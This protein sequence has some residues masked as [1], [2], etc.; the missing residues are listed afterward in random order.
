VPHR[1]VLSFE[2]GLK[3]PATARH[4]LAARLPELSDDARRDAMIV[5]SELVTNAVLAGARAL[6][7]VVEND[8]RRLRVEVEED[9][10]S[11]PLSEWHGLHL[12]AA[13]AQSCGTRR[14]D[15]GETS[16]AELPVHG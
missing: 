7:L 5:V 4:A 2:A 11:A 12:V 10:R 16:W 15:H 9:G 8:G 14:H 3:A 13:L 1:V 6:Q